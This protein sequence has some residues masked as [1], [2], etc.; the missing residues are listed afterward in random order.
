M[1][2]SFDNFLKK[3]FMKESFDNF[4]KRTFMKDEPERVGDKDTFDDN[5]DRWLEYQGT[6]LIIVYAEKWHLEQT[7]YYLK[8]K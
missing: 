1:K 7:L 4:L 8:N 2:E 5:F 3:A 6:D